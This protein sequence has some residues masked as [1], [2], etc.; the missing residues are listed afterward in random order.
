MHYRLN[1]PAPGRGPWWGGDC[2]CSITPGSLRGNAAGLEFRRLLDGQ[3]RVWPFQN[4]VQRLEPAF[5]V[6]FLSV[7]QRNQN[8]TYFP[9]ECLLL[10]FDLCRV[11]FFISIAP[12]IPRTRPWLPADHIALCS[13]RFLRPFCWLFQVHCLRL[14]PL[15]S[16]RIKATYGGIRTSRGGGCSSCTE[17]A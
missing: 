15:R 6:S 11:T 3:L 17:G 8:A 13:I 12:S 5:V 10:R 2:Q 4:L 7:L 16:R 14:G 1:V 9:C